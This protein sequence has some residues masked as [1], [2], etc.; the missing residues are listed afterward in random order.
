MS[1]NDT[2]CQDCKSYHHPMDACIVRT[3]VIDLFPKDEELDGW[4]LKD[5]LIQAVSQLNPEDED[6]IDRMNAII[7]VAFIIEED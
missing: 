1:A 3:N 5:R 7:D 2:Y 6:D 4:E